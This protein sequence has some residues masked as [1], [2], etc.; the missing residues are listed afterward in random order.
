MAAE[1]TN[2][3]A[4]M[5][6]KRIDKGKGKKKDTIS[7]FNDE[8]DTLVVQRLSAEVS[9]KAQK[10]SRIGAREFV[11]YEYEEFTIENIRR[12]CEKHF[13][14]DKSMS[15]DILAGEQGPS[16]NTV[17]QI[18]D[19]RVIHVRF[20][21]RVPVVELDEGTELGTRERGPSLKSLPAKRKFS[22][23]E[24]KTRS[25]P[26]KSAPSPSKFV[27]RS[28]SVVE[29]LKLGKVITQSTTSVNIYAFNFNE[30][31]WS[32]TPST[33]DFSIGKEPFGKGGFRQAFKATSNDK[34]FQGTWVIKK[35]L[36]KSIS[37][38]ESTG[39]SI[40]QHTKKV[41]QMHY[42]ARNFAARLS[43]ELQASDDHILF[44][45]TPKYNKIS[46][47]KLDSDEYVT[48]EELV[49]GSFVK[50]I[51]NNGHI[52]GD[53]NN[54]VCN[55]A[56]CLAHY[57]FE[58]SNKEVMVVD[59]QGCDYLLFDPEVASKELKSNEE[60]FFCTGNLS[61]SAINNFIESHKCNWY[62]ELLK[63]P[64]LTNL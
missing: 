52:C 11:S 38:I 32:T 4:K 53:T 59:I 56:E 31:S 29:M 34:E 7:A 23:A 6:A 47:G 54:P 25:V 2:F 42:L 36:P 39:Q 35:Y 63:L 57:S 37:D 27:P 5:K 62:C 21:E 46:L 13:A 19:S 55:K 28:L 44:G 22:D 14:V 41:V 50:H 51:N 26:T 10:Y 1:W 30:M 45:E 49:E 48:V 58:R 9:G 43:Q 20:V 16:C 8:N 18:P 64:E 12:A 40:E 17:K 15:C 61:I 33:V 24:T 60:F 3:K